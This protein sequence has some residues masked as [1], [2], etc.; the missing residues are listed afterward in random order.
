MSSVS[1]PSGAGGDAFAAASYAARDMGFGTHAA[2]LVVDFQ[3]AFTDPDYPMG[4][5]EH[6]SSAVDQTAQ[7]IDFA[8]PLGVPV[9]SCSIGWHSEGDMARWKIGAVYN[10]MFYGDKSLETDP[11]L[12]GKTDF[13]FIKSAPSMFFGTPLNT[14]LN[15]QGVDTVLITGATTSGCVRATIVDAFSHGYRVI[16]PEDCCGD[17]ELEAH[18]ANLRDVSR[19]YADVM[20][21]EQVRLALNTLYGDQTNGNA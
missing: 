14:F 21:S 6:V 20:P 19:R 18:R 2:I 1:D 11:R 4:R 12:A 3:R 10:D 15:K 9:A 7:L 13:H 5:S 8:R 16:V 17:Q